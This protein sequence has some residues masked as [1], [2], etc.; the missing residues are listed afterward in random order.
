MRNTPRNYYGYILLLHVI[1]KN[2]FLSRMDQ[3]RLTQ[4][5]LCRVKGGG[6]GGGSEGGGDLSQYNSYWLHHCIVSY[7]YFQKNL[8]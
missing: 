6:G 7:L 3:S 8:Y 5:R 1:Q 4:Y 2:L